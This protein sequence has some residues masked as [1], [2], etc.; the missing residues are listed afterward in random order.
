VPVYWDR[1]QG[2]PTLTKSEQTRGAP[3]GSGRVA[4]MCKDSTRNAEGVAA[5]GPEMKIE[6]PKQNSAESCQERH[7]HIIG[8]KQSISSL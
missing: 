4:Q 6:W 1:S 5:H 8:R 2:G 3:K 7:T